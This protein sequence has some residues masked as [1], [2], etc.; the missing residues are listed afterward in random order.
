[1][2]T[3]L[4]SS[5]S[6]ARV[7]SWTLIYFCLRTGYYDE[8]RNVALSSRV[9]QQFAP[10]WITSGGMVSAETAAAASEECEK[11]L[12]MSDRKWVDLVRDSQGGGSFVLGEGMVPY[13]LDDLQETRDEG[14]DID[15]GP[16]FNRPSRLWSTYGRCRVWPQVRSDG[17]FCRSSL[18]YEVWCSILTLGN[19]AMALEY[20][21][22]AAAAMGGGQLSWTGQTNKHQQRQ[23]LSMLKQLLTELLL[24]IKC[25]SLLLGLRGAGEE[26]ELRRFLTDGKDQQ[27]FCLKPLVN[28]RRLV[29]LK[30][31]QEREQI[32]EYQTV[33][34]QLEA[35]LSIHKLARA[36][37]CTDALKEVT[38]LS[39]LPLDP[40]GPDIM[41]Y[42]F[43]RLSPYVQ[44]CVPDLLKVALSCLDNMTD[45]DGVLR[46][47]RTKVFHNV[48]RSCLKDDMVFTGDDD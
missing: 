6:R 33:L 38:K 19:L 13:T 25:V 45:S 40:R 22:Q 34:R 35:I 39:F 28:V 16:H 23:K 9:S 32:L 37:Q 7:L 5:C 29:F 27:Q 15:A 48:N 36:G 30:S 11:M 20:Y 14:F 12:R 42:E 3:S 4:I 31:V 21:A 2:G 47:L 18:L 1:M 17:C 8:A 24:L 44:A 41:T 43:Q 10:Q 26:G 46:A